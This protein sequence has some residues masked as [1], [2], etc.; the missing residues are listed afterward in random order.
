MGFKS[1]GRSGRSARRELATGVPLVGGGCRYPFPA[2]GFRYD[3]VRFGRDSGMTPNGRLKAP[4][5]RT[6]SKVMLSFQCSHQ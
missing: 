2:L 4:E 1:A 3:S 6:A 5:R